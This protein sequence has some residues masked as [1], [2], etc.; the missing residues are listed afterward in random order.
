[1]KKKR[2]ALLFGSFN[3][4][5]RGH[6]GLAKDLL[7]QKLADELWFVVSPNNPLKNADQLMDQHLRLKMVE[8]AIQEIPNTL[9]CNIEF[10]MTIP[11]YTIDTLNLLHSNYPD[12]HFILLIGSDNALIFNKWRNYNEILN[13]F[14]VMVYPRKGYDFNSVSH[15]YPQMKLIQTPFYEISSTL[16]R[17]NLRNDPEISKWLHPE[18]YQTLLKNPPL[19]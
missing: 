8:M 15:L 1:M 3:P 19:P 13:H 18:V 7:N 6:T 9:A 2:T 10:F 16:I 12:H 17:D 11:S 4:I 14:E 5:H